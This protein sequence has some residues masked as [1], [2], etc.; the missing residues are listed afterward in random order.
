MCF[1]LAF[2]SFSP[3]YFGIFHIYFYFLFVLFRSIRILVISWYLFLFPLNIPIIFYLSIF[4]YCSPLS[5]LYAL[6]IGLSMHLLS[7][8]WL[9]SLFTFLHGSI[10]K[11]QENCYICFLPLHWFFKRNPFPNHQ[12]CTCT[13]SLA[14]SLFPLFFFFW[15]PPLRSHSVWAYDT[16]LSETERKCNE[17]KKRKVIY[18][19]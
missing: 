16:I 4:S 18:V 5:F 19:E 13:V 17:K 9:S 6:V 7:L 12:S 11:Q 15:F 14:H 2:T 10:R 3:I 1:N 8:D